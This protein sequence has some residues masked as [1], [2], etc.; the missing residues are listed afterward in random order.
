MAHVTCHLLAPWTSLKAAELSPDTPTRPPSLIPLLFP[1]SASHF[2]LPIRPAE[3]P[4]TSKTTCFLEHRP[5]ITLQEFPSCPFVSP[6]EQK[7]A[8]SFAQSWHDNC[9]VGAHHLPVN[10]WTKEGPNNQMGPEVICPGASVC[11]KS[12]QSSPSLCNP[13]DHNLPG[14]LVH[15][16]LHARTVEWVAMPFSRGIFPTQGSKLHLLHLLH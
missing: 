11:A 14:S 10:K 3:F 2:L 8:T 4:S 1:V 9:L 7:P 12:L 13:T 6:E 16:I 5:L 15:Q